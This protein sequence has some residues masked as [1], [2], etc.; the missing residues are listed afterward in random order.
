MSTFFTKYKV[1]IFGLLASVAVTVEQFATGT[2]DYKVIG[3]AILMAVVS[4]FA[5][6]VKGQWAT[7]VGIVGTTLASIIPGLENHTPISWLQIA[8]QTIAAILAIFIP[9]GGTVTPTPTPVTTKT[10]TSVK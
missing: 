5:K 1:F 9:T 7:I 6:N 3:Y 2:S 8:G 4:F 10:T